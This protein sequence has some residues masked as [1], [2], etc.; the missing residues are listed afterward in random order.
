MK[1]SLLA[2]GLT[3]TMVLAMATPAFAANTNTN[4]NADGTVVTAP[5][6]PDYVAGGNTQTGG[7]SYNEAN[8]S[9]KNGTAWET[10]NDDDKLAG[11]ADANGADIN[12]WAKVTDSGSKVYK[13]DLAW[14]A[15]KFE[16]NGGGGQWNTTSH[17]YDA[18]TGGTAAWTATYLDGINNK[19]AV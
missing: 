9:S 1:K 12:V 13:V 2:M 16:Y 8:I 11:A 5:G 7:Q 6:S 17:T 14:G 4:V 3:L 10:V 18:A 15:M 19:V